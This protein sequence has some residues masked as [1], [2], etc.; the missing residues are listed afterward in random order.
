M[1]PD[2]H[3]VKPLSPPPLNYYGSQTKILGTSRMI[4]MG[5]FGS[6]F[7]TTECHIWEKSDE[8]CFQEVL[9]L[10]RKIDVS[11][12]KPAVNPHRIRGNMQLRKQCIKTTRI[13]S[14]ST[15][16]GPSLSTMWET[17]FPRN[18]QAGLGRPFYEP[19]ILLSRSTSP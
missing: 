7:Y 13:R 19:N 15:G 5:R 12:V 9:R 2:V 18:R 4:S 14:K 10:T 1:V 17:T 6:T 3:T 8:K 11:S 16:C